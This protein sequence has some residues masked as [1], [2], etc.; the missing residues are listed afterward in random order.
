[1]DRVH[2]FGSYYATRAVNHHVIEVYLTLD[3]HALLVIRVVHA[4]QRGT[5]HG[6]LNVL[7]LTQP[8]IDRDAAELV[9]VGYGG[10][11]H[12]RQERHLLD[13][14]DLLGVCL[15]RVGDLQQLRDAVALYVVADKCLG[16]NDLLLGLV[17]VAGQVK[18][19]HLAVEVLRA[20]VLDGLGV[21]ALCQ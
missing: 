4:V 13:V 2:R 21:V 8:L 18:G 15:A 16:N 17:H 10:H 19:A 12:E 20:G 7:N 6:C 5:Q 11:G 9:W 3:N 14:E 1:M